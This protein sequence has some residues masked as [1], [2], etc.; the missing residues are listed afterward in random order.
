MKK[1]LIVFLILM[2]IQLR[3]LAAIDGFAMPLPALSGS[4]TV[5]AGKVVILQQV[6]TSLTAGSWSFSITAINPNYG[7]GFSTIIN[8]PS[9]N[10]NGLY[11]FA[12]PLKLPGGTTINYT[13]GG[14]MML[15]G[16]IVDVA[17]MSLFTAAVSTFGPISIAQNTLSGEL[18]LPTSDPAFIRIQSSTNMVDW[19][20]D[21]SVRVQAGS[22]KNKVRFTVPA[23]G[24]GHYY[25]A[26]VIRQSGA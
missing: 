9:A 17:D 26:L 6:S 23:A 22:S 18:Q 13:S 11:K 7:V 20:Y 21:S 1:S 19:V 15:H 2:L 25:R 8:I 16:L 14:V 4:Y 3:I 24:P 5:P 12:S 10:T